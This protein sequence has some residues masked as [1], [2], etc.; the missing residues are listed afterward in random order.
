MDL[1]IA[2]VTLVIVI[3][4]L[5]YLVITVRDEIDHD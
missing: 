1:F 4:A 5:A 3:A 2:C